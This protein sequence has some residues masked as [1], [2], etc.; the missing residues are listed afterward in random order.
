[1]LIGPCKQR[2]NLMGATCSAAPGSLLRI[3]SAA[4]LFL[5][6]IAQAKGVMP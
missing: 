6:V 3:A 1:M 4:L 2:D 5:W